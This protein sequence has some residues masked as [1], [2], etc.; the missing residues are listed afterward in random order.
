MTDGW[1]KM[2][3]L[4]LGMFFYSF[5]KLLFRLHVQEPRQRRM[6][7]TRQHRQSKTNGNSRHICFESQVSFFVILLYLAN[8]FF[9]YIINYDARPPHLTCKHGVSSLR[10][11][12]F[13]FIFTILNYYYLG[14]VTMTTMNDHYTP[15]LPTQERDSRRICVEPQVSFYFTITY[16]QIT[17]TGTRQRMTTTRQRCQRKLGIFF[18]YSILFY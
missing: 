5:T 6:A 7:T 2:Q 18:C 10:P 9:S 3:V 13:S 16:N 1:L 4:E 15:A 17:C 12:Y 8:C 11:R 14:T